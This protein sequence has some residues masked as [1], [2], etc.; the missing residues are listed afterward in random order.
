MTELQTLIDRQRAESFRPGADVSDEKVLGVLIA[1]HLRWDGAAI[2][3]VAVAALVD[4]N[5]GPLA[6]HLREALLLSS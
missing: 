6:N 5:F 4:A 1:H 2:A 3:E